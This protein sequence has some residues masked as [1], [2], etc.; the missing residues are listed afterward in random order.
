MVSSLQFANSMRSGALLFLSCVPLCAWAQNSEPIAQPIV[1]TIPPARDVVSPGTLG[2]FV[3]ATD[4]THG[5]FRVHETV[6]VVGAGRLTLLYPKWLPGTHSPGGP[7]ANVAGIEFTAGEHALAWKRDPVDVYA[8]HVE[9]PPG[10]PS[11]EAQFQ[12]LAPTDLA[13]GRITQTPTMADLQWNT[14]VL[15]PAGYYARRIEVEASVKLPQGWRYGTALEVHS[16]EDNVV[17][18]KPVPLD[19]LVD[20]PLYAGEYFRV[21]P[22]S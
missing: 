10:T 21:E 3:D 15:Y 7:I 5:I 19:V 11:L 12:Y 6:P 2:L 20:S 8:F 1:I 13:Q 9:I 17:R 22:L 18:F 16:S 4:N 14:V